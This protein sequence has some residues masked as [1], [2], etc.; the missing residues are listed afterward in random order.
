MYIDIDK[1]QYFSIHHI[2]SED[3]L[4]IA[5]CLNKSQNNRMVRLGK[6]LT[7]EV[8]KSIAENQNNKAPVS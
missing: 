3:A 2:A 8:A 7:I 6:K 5:S 4:L 1:L